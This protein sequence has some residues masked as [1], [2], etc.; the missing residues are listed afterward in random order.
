MKSPQDPNKSRET[1]N[2]KSLLEIVSEVNEENAKEPQELRSSE[3][4]DFVKEVSLTPKRKQIVS[5]D[6]STKNTPYILEENFFVLAKADSP[7]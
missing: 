1:H 2:K 3:K 6:F 7:W 5:Q 4:I